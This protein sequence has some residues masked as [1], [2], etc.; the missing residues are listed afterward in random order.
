MLQN[1][2]LEN[3]FFL[4]LSKRTGSI[5]QKTILRIKSYS[6]CIILSRLYGYEEYVRL[7]NRNNQTTS[8]I[9]LRL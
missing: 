6:N 1:I 4:F 7:T 2:I 9:H 5:D 8:L 3:M